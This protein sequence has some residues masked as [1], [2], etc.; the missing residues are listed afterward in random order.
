MK[1]CTLIAAGVTVIVTVPY[2]H[3][4]II[5]SSSSSSSS[6]IIRPERGSTC[7]C[8]NSITPTWTA[9]RFWAK[10]VTDLVWDLLWVTELGHY[11]T[12][13]LGLALLS[14]NF[15][16]WTIFLL[17]FHAQPSTSCQFYTSWSFITIFQNRVPDLTTV[18][19]TNIIKP[20]RWPWIYKLK[21]TQWLN[22]RIW[23]LN[24]ECSL[25]SI[26]PGRS[27]PVY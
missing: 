10:T 1:S 22:L 17:N 5:S 3:Q 11:A 20:A 7:L 14:L 23:N 15:S 25:V 2:L 12:S 26:Q 6:I 4:I 27:Q 19:Q 18:E 13:F 9:T 16:A 24:C 21:W 8:P